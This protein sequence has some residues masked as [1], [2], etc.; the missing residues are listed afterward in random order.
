MMIDRST[1]LRG[2]MF[3]ADKIAYGFNTPSGI[4][5]S[6]VNF[7]SDQPVKGT[8]TVGS[9][10]VTYNS[11][12]T[13]SA[14]TFVLDWFRLSDLTG[15]GSYR[16]LSERG[17][18]YLLNPSPE[19]VYPGLIGTQFDV[20]NG[21]LLTFDGGWQAGVDSFL[22]YLIKT[23]QYQVTP[24]TKQYKDFWLQAIQSTTEHLALHP[25]GFPDLT[26]LS[27]LDVNGTIAY[28]QDD[29]SCFAGGNY[30]LGGKLL[31]SPELVD[32]GLAVT[33]GC[34]QLYNTT[35]SGLGPLEWAWYNENNEAYNPEDDHNTPERKWAA[36][37]GYFIP[38][39]DE[40][41]DVRPEPIESLFY[42]HRITGDPIWQEYAWQVFVAINETA[43]NDIGFAEVN[44][45]NMPYGGT[46]NNAL[47]SFFFAE[48]L[49]YL[50]LTFSDPN[51]VNLDQWVF[52]TEAHP[53][54]VQCGIGAIDDH[55]A[56]GT[57]A[58][59]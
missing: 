4:A 39:G 58:R 57:A 7:T 48:V 55:G 1:D 59:Q 37:Y 29:F 13:A 2:V 34:H 50:Y 10:N 24:T 12:N 40:S 43:R 27:F 8:Y 38:E 42:A 53:L 19:P 44:N 23:Y 41:W 25:Y 18:E 36:K 49:K 31:D 6:N 30:L 14:G 16:Y 33:D 45:V 20:D 3:L 46:L 11:T 26:L 56:N 17:Q 9:T 47:D 54:L 22:E 52:N 21:A 5:S 28:T 32:L 51:V 15:N 35:V